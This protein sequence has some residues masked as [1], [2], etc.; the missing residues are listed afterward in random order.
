MPSTNDDRL[1][2]TDEKTGF[3]F[4][5]ATV[6][7]A[8]GFFYIFI[9]TCLVLAG[10]P[11]PVWPGPKNPLAALAVFALVLM[12]NIYQGA[13]D[14]DP[15]QSLFLR[16][17]LQFLAALIF[18]AGLLLI[19]PFFLGAA[20]FLLNLPAAAFFSAR[21]ILADPQNGLEPAR[22]NLGAF[23]G[24]ALEYCQ[25]RKFA[26][27]GATAVFLGVFALRRF[28]CGPRWNQSA[29]WGALGLAA[30]A[31]LIFIILAM[32]V[33]GCELTAA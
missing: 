1:P 27:P 33:G 5:P 21:E 7:Y 23:L 9:S 3:R 22:Q 6:V 10:Q 2:Q 26:A 16:R 12:W 8:A 4:S 15:D 14:G 28:R 20:V 32:L 19:W 29:F 24:L 30:L 13:D 11:T 17:A 25:S 31:A 18:T